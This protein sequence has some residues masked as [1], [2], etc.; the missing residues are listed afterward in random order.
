MRGGH[1]SRQNRVDGVAECAGEDARLPRQVTAAGVDRVRAHQHDDAAEAEDEARQPG[2][3]DGLAA[4]PDVGEQQRDQRIR[5]HQ[6][7][8][9]PA[10]H[11]LLPPAD[12]VER[13]GVAHDPE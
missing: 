1:A 6:D 12:Q 10:R 4:H 9:H 11:A 8:G 3:R 2:S 5:A 7:S 13:H